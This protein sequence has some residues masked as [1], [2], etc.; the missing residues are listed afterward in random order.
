MDGWPPAERDYPEAEWQFTVLALNPKQPLPVK[1]GDP[2]H[3]LTPGNV[4]EQFNDDAIED[5]D[6]VDLARSAVRAVLDGR[7]IPEPSGIRGAREAWGEA[8][9]ATI[10]HMKGLHDE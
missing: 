8:I 5:D 9:A 6:V 10:A 1:D 4:Q 2:V 7:L 3:F